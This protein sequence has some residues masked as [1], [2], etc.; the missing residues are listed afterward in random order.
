MR[1]QGAVVNPMHVRQA[2]N[3]RQALAPVPAA[4]VNKH[5]SDTSTTLFPTF[6][7]PSV[8]AD[9]GKESVN[10]TLPAT[11]QRLKRACA[12]LQVTRAQLDNAEVQM[13]E[14]GQLYKRYAEGQ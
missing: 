13:Y 10:L 9:S 3:S 12:G 7:L 11:R 6:E 1:K 4:S 8:K 2:K 5:G 14:L